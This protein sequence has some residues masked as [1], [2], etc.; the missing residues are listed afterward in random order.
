MQLPR[1]VLHRVAVFLIC[2]TAWI[3]SAGF[4]SAEAITVEGNS[5]VDTATIQSY[6]T[7]STADGVKALKDTGMFSSVTTRQGPGGLVV[8][9]AEN[10]VIN[11]VAFEGNSKVKSEQLT[12]EVQSKSRGAFDTAVAQADIGRIQEVYRRGGRADATATY[13][14]VDLPNGKVDVVFTVD[15]GSKTG[16]KSIEFTGNQAFSSRKLRGLMQTTEMNYISF[17]KTSDVY[18]P[19]KIATD[20]ELIRRFYLRNGYADFRIINTDVKFNPEDKGYNVAIAIEEGQQYKVAAVSVDSRLRGVGNDRLSGFLRTEVGDVY[21]GDDVEKTVDVLTRETGRLGYAF[22]Q[23]RPRGD[24]DAAN[25]SVSIQYVIDEGPRVYIERI[26]IRG[27]TRTRDYV[28]RREFDV[29]EGDPYNKVLID[30]AERRLNALGFFKKVRITNEPGSAPDRVVINVDLE[31]QPTG[32]FSISGGY[33]TT[34]GFIAE[35][36]VTETNFLGRGDYVRIAAS[37]GQY[38]RGVDLSFT[39]PY[40]LDTRIAGGVDLFAKENDN[41]SYSYYSTFVTGGT[42]RL[43]I[44]VTDEFSV[45]PHYSLYNTRISIPNKSGE[46]YNDCTNP[47]N[48]TTPGYGTLINS[49][50]ATN[51]CLTNGEASVAIKESVGDTL[52]SLVGVNLNYNTLDNLSAPTS[53]LLVELRNDVAGLGGDSQFFRS[54][55]DLRYFHPIYDD[56]VGIVHLQGGSIEGFGDE[57]QLRIADEFQL[58]PTLVRGFAPGGIGPRDISDLANYKYNPL[59]GSHYYGASVESQFPLYGLPRD[60]GLKGAVFA[61]MGSLFGYNGKTNFSSNGTC[62]ASNT[63]PLYTQGTCVD[64]RDSSAIRSSVGASLIWNSPLGP[65]RFDYAYALSKDKYDVTQAFRFSGGTK[66]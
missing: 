65:L 6:F 47:I 29:G 50:S 62:T 10:T 51:N 63:S 55:G 25:H 22:A 40:L 26:N 61:D 17:F 37:E 9:V 14:V 64:V 30:R 28:I 31:D 21:N 4:A 39:E 3:G 7:G 53:G 42:L 12:V 1:G 66:F 49:L 48:G 18:D 35:V 60:L 33:S 44:P 57:K 56:I 34:D 2:C 43:G 45:S 41:N 23:V 16:V 27:N 20:E 59:G 8:R 5:R 54:S 32:S 38:S 52:T 36:A 24:R 19:D 11:R 13:R 58:G 15:E 46:P